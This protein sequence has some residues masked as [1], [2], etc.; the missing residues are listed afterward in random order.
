[1]RAVW[2]ARALSLR[3]GVNKTPMPQH[4]RPLLP[5]RRR[6]WAQRSPPAARGAPATVAERE[7]R[8]KE[9]AERAGV[10]RTTLDHMA[11]GISVVDADLRLVAWNQKFLDLLDFPERFAV[12]HIA[13]EEFVRYNAQRG[14]Y[15]PGDIEA[16]VRS[17]VAIARQFQPHRFKR[18]RPDGKV[19][20]IRGEP[21]PGGGFV[22][23]YTDITE[24]ERAAEALRGSEERFRDIAEF[25][26]DWFWEQ[27]NELRFTYISGGIPSLEHYDASAVLGKRR[28]E[29]PIEG[30]SPQQWAEHRSALERRESF[31]SFNYQIRTP[32][33]ELR[34]YSVSGKPIFDAQGGFVGYRGTGSDI[35]TQKASEDAIR[36]LN[37]TL[38]QKVQERTLRLEASNRE[39]EAFSYSVSHDLRSPLR[40]IGGFAQVLRQGHTAQ[41]DGDGLAH[42]D[43]ILAATQR[44]AQLIDDMLA[45]ARIT[46]TPIHRRPVDF[47]ALARLVAQEVQD[48]EAHRV[49]FVAAAGIHILADPS[50]LR[51][52]LENLLR[53]AWKFTRRSAAPRVEFGAEAGPS[54]PKFFVRDNGVGFDM[55]YAEKLFQPFQRLHLHDEFEGSGIGLATVQRV[56]ALHAG[57]A[58]AQSTPGGGATFFFT[59]P[60]PPAD[61]AST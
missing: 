29:L 3:S 9:L 6:S 39:L 47:S 44:M 21:L 17:R 52:V 28:W 48:H 46:R 34:W 42:L 36:H 8:L 25:A 54:G 27:D 57:E 14:E 26:N 30:V 33:G 53:N 60:E 43:R 50:L 22:T 15:G 13:F 11:Q 55:R 19:V 58:W 31:R 61:P 51:I 38:E 32:A 49:E 56:L 10:L 4:P 23:T 45:L 1:M 18:T 37:S 59:L 35:S 12:E 5:W 7:H 41:L 40:S 16:Q 2:S 20:E 24:S